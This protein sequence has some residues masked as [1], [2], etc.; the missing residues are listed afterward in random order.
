MIRPATLDREVSSV[1]QIL[2]RPDWTGEPFRVGAG[3]SCAAGMTKSSEIP[4]SSRRHHPSRRMDALMS[5]V[6]FSPVGSQRGE[7][8]TPA[9]LGTRKIAHVYRTAVGLH[10][11]RTT[12]ISASTPSTFI[13]YPEPDR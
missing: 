5:V 12:G 2:Q 8:S 6:P 7:C 4:S 10:L 1:I 3:G 11:S 9:G 13:L